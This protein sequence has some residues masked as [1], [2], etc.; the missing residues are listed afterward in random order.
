MKYT[1]IEIRM[2]AQLH[3]LGRGK[4]ELRIPKID[5]GDE[6]KLSFHNGKEKKKT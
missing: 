2:K 3:D 1:T 6:I 4:L 5:D